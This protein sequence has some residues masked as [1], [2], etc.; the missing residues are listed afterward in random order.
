VLP[1]GL[2]SLLHWAQELSSAT[3]IGCLRGSEALPYQDESAEHDIR[4]YLADS[5]SIAFQKSKSTTLRL[6]ED[7]S[8]TLLLLGVWGR[9]SNRVGYKPRLPQSGCTATVPI[10]PAHK[11]S[12]LNQTE[13]TSFLHYPANRTEVVC[14]HIRLRKFF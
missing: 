3:L 13:I 14:L 5:P 12:A 9:C 6:S 10:I 2:A 8:Q 1:A 7:Q 11:P 4:G